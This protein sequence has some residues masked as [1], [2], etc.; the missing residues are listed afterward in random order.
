MNTL[1]KQIWY[2]GRKHHCNLCSAHVRTWIWVGLNNEVF[3]R[4]E[5][6]GAGRRKRGCPICHATDRDRLMWHF[7]EKHWNNMFENTK[8]D[9]LHFAPE[10]YLIGFLN[11]HTKRYVK[12]DF[13]A[14][15]YHYTS[16]TLH[17]DVQQIPFDSN[18]WDMVIANHV[19]E[20]VQ[21]DHQA[22]NEIFR[23]L[24]P[25]GIAILQVPLS[26]YM[27]ETIEVS[28]ESEDLNY[29]EITGQFDHKRL[30]GLDFFNRLKRS[31]FE[32]EFWSDHDNTNRLGFHPEERIVM[33]R[34]IAEV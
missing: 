3:N 29:E 23:V 32:I 25:G 5:M 27:Y 31:N 13:F 28:D 21:N 16:D 8:P 7:F 19:L 20:H 10:S 12:G 6:V 34:K 2:W 24:K 11:A 17:M 9:V 18:T 15:G 30:Y 1:L 33:A 26:L 22:L 14:P 4:H